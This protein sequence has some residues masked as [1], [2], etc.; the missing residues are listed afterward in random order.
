MFNKFSL[1]RMIILVTIIGFG[2]LLLDVIIEHWGVFDKEIMVYIP[3]SYCLLVLF[4]GGMT[5]IRWNPKIIRIFKILLFISFIVSAAGLYFHL[6][7]EE[8]DIN[9]TMEQKDHEESEKD[10]SIIAPLAFSG[11][12]VFG[13]LGTSKKWKAENIE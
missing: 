3:V 5:V 12:A 9:L 6:E 7:E 2:A 11:L 13:L 4:L 10:K 1:N 8:D